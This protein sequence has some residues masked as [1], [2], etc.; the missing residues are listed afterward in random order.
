MAAPP[1][2][3]TPAAQADD[4]LKRPLYAFDIPRELLKSL[5]VKGSGQDITPISEPLEPT[6]DEK[7]KEFLKEP[8]PTSG[9]SCTLCG[10]KSK[11]VQEQRSHARSDV[12]RFN[13]KRK[14][15]KEPPVS[16]IEFE[17]M[18]EALDESI[19]GSESSSTEDEQSSDP[20]ATLLR[21][22]ATIKAAEELGEDSPRKPR[23]PIIWM[24]SPMLPEST[25]VGVYRAILPDSTEESEVTQILPTL[26]TQTTTALPTASDPHIFLCMIGGGH[27]AAMIVSLIPKLV[28]RSGVVERE[29]VVL[30]H[31]TFHR[32]TTRRKQGGSQSANDNSKGTAHS[33]GSSLRRYNEAA[34]TA[35]IRELLGNWKEM[36]DSSS[37]L[38]IR[39]TGT[40]NRKTLFGGDNPVI[41]STD[42][43][44][45]GFPFTT[46]RAT[47]SELMRC[48]VEVTRLKVSKIDETVTAAPAAATSSAPTPKAPVAKPKPS[49]EE[50]LKLQHT[51]TLTTL[52]RRSKAP[53]IITYLNS[54]KLP[55]T[56]YFTP[57]NHHTPT[58][59]HLAASQSHP[60]IVLALLTKAPN[61]NKEPAD[62]TV[63]NSAG[64][65][66]YDLAGDK[67]TREIFRVARQELG[68][69]RFD[70]ELLGVGS[71]ISRKEYDE[72]T[73][74][75]KTAKDAEEKDRRDKETARLRNMPDTSSSS[76]AA[77]KGGK[78]LAE[79]LGTNAATN[80]REEETKGLSEEAKRRLERERRARAA[81]ERMKRLAGK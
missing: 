7:L 70:W 78:S 16:E 44:I 66:P 18:I 55:F 15:R 27:F 52:L 49:K 36:L 53:A 33:A 57:T 76:S 13:M 17:K 4:L 63:K 38:F 25:Y 74:R 35:D 79:V 50:A 1:P 40:S 21:K 80:A 3:S 22:K 11:T 2:P 45:R 60:T 32:Y 9:M 62:P 61:G 48:F 71:S 73:E 26:Q 58:L 5:V 77:S 56:Y 81:E 67:A 59:L 24:S 46:R 51:T 72:A 34:L 68:E 28:K 43:R 12:H 29:A 47:Q 64:K 65:T 20:L 8:D 30:A 6:E 14:I 54:N 39:A 23:T 10:V 37:L 31:K 42:K 41:R 75:E 69:D 19:S